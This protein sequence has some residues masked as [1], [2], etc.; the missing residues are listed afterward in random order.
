MAY[1][2]VRQHGGKI[3][4]YSEPGV[5]TVFRIYLPMTDHPSPE[6][7]EKEDSSVQGG[8]ET[9]LLVEDAPEVRDATRAILECVGYTV[10]SADNG[11]EAIKMFEQYA[12]GISLVILDVIM[13]DMDGKE[14]WD[15][16]RVMRRDIRVLFVSGYTSDI[17]YRKGILPDAGNFLSK[18][19]E[20][21]LFLKRVRESIDA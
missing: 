18:P 4:V 7:P 6:P 15:V 2:I 11:L 12:E 5:G 8:G 17:L 1:G 10:I 16:L 13:P 3:N 9:I 21:S 20:T 19:L 14:V